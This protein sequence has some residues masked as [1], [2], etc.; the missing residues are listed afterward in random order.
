MSSKVR[1]KA[2][3]GQ[4]EEIGAHKFEITE[5]M[6]MTFEGTSC[7]IQDGKRDLVESLGAVDGQVT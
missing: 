4:T 1:E 7:N 2:L 5:T 3:S 6:T